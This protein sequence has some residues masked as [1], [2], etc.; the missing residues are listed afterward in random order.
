MKTKRA[1][2]A[3]SITALV[4]TV[5]L[6]SL[7]AYYIAIALVLGTLIL[8][9]REFWSLVT[10]RKMPPIDERV[11]DNINKS[12]RNGFIFLALAIAFLM[13]PFAT[14]LIENPAT[15]HLLGGLFVSGAMVYLLS[16]FY[17]D[18]VKPSLNERWLRM[19]KTFLLVAGMSIGVFIISV[20]LHNFLGGL[21]GFEEPVFF[22]IAVIIC[23]LT[24]AVGIIG[25]LAIFIKGL[26]GKPS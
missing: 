3:V 10:L 5:L 16:Y 21:L 4:I 26:A 25:S 7:E 19:F 17:Y 22:V 12:V 9:Y 24:L 11:Q 1:F 6:I 2:L 14:T 20:V 18:R 15:I 8:G 23:P 13:L